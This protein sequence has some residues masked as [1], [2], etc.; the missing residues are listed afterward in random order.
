ML[1]F[2]SGLYLGLRHPS[3]A[4]EP[5]VALSQGRPAALQEPPGA[6]AVAARLACLQGCEAAVLLPSTLHLFWDLFRL[7]GSDPITVLVDAGS[8]AIARWGAQC[9]AT[10]GIRVVTFTH[11]DVE[12][13]ARLAH[14]AQLRRQCPVIVADGYCTQCGKIAPLAGYADVARTCNGYLVLDDTQALGIL[15][16]NPDA[17][18]PYGKGGGGSLRWQ[19]ISG[20]HIM[21]GASLAKAFGAP[22]AVLAGSRKLV[23]HFTRESETRLHCSPPSLAAI[24]AAR[25]ALE[26]NRTCGD[27]L[28]ARLLALVS[29]LRQHLRRIGLQPA[30]GLPFPVQSFSARPGIRIAALQ[31]HLIDRRV[32][33]LLTAPDGGSESRLTFL[34]TAGHSPGDI[35]RVAALLAPQLSDAYRE[36]P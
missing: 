27:A 17:E 2:T 14:Q 34:V 25:R 31:R 7:L 30:G 11:H 6:A 20:P 26:L 1:D 5:W 36:A 18:R 12:A 23:E 29:R 21:V 32:R 4:L 9:A 15:G 3:D 8:Y 35:D 13:V 33:T 10:H 24:A 16:A 28:R 22:V 19:R